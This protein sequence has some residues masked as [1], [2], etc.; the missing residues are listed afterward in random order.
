M[1]ATRTQCV[2][3]FEEDLPETTAIGDLFAAAQFTGHVRET[4][5]TAGKVPTLYV[6][7]GRRDMIKP[8]TLRVAYA[9]A[10][11]KLAHLGA[12]EVETSLFEGASDSHSLV[13]AVAEGLVMGAYQFEAYQ[14]DQR[15]QVLEW[16]PTTETPGWRK[17]MRVAQAVKAVRD[18]VNEPANRLGPQDLADHCVRVADDAGITVAVRDQQW[19]SDN[20]AGGILAM[21]QGSASA[22]Y[23][24]ELSAGAEDAPLDFC[25]VGKGVTF[26]TGGLSLKDPATMIGMQDDMAGAAVVL[27]AMAMLPYIAPQLNVRA[28]LPLVENMPGPGSIRPGDVITSRSGKTIE[29]LNTDFEGRVI[30]ADA[31]AFA[32]EQRPQVVVDIATLTYGS[33]AALGSRTAALFGTDE[34]TSLIESSSETTGEPVWRL[35][36]P[37]HLAPTVHSQTADVKNFPGEPQARASTAAMFL[38]EFITDGIPWAHLDIAGP[39]WTR[40]PQDLTTH[41]ATGFGTRLLIDLLSRHRADTP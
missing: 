1:T 24:V 34:A 36:M 41:G 22:P 35:P 3:Y 23:M 13:Q 28:Y 15:P 12:V 21:G 6:G 38:R 16:H 18:I 27:H 4:M 11:K 30:M 31:L 33:S 37:D 10:G 25:L 39:A 20:G 19:L 26:D 32:C 17:G 7:C 5:W 2:P 14:T 9:A 40:E 8:A 29:I